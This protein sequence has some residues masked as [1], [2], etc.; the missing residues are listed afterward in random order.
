MKVFEI[1]AIQPEN[2]RSNMLDMI[3]KHEQLRYFL[4]PSI[5]F[6]KVIEGEKLNSTSD[7]KALPPRNIEIVLK[8]R[9]GGNEIISPERHHQ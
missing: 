2:I 8:R 7:H 9:Y 6:E 1:K 3:G 4:K 5:K